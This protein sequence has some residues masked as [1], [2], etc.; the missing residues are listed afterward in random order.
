MIISGKFTFYS[1]TELLLEAFLYIF[2]N[3]TPL[4]QGVIDDA[5]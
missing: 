2:H 1:L 4:F 5:S 3:I